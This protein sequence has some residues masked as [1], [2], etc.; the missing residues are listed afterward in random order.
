M[1]PDG[2]CVCGNVLLG[3]ASRGLDFL[4]P[5]PRVEG[6]LLL[7]GPPLAGPLVIPCTPPWPW[8][9][10]SPPPIRR[11]RVGGGGDRSGSGVGSAPH[12]DK[13]PPLLPR[14]RCRCRQTL[15]LVSLCAR[16]KIGTVK[17]AASL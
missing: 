4:S 6:A 16:T 11:G 13:K 14:G 1:G 9:R 10:Q 5:T 3:R 15:R 17:V 2:A 8:R 12:E 7:A